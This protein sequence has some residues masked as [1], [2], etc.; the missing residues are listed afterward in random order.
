M[1]TRTGRVGSAC[2]QTRDTHDGERRRIKPGE[3]GDVGTG[4]RRRVKA[5]EPGAALHRT[6]TACL[7]GANRGRFRPVGSAKGRRGGER[8]G[9]P[10]F[11]IK[12]PP[13]FVTGADE[14]PR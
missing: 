8:M 3:S 6:D 4:E 14:P 2:P 5:G 1:I 11:G 12:R 7:N 10:L 9:E 13:T